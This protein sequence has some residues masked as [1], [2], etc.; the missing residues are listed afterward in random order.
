[1]FVGS[2]RSPFATDIAGAILLGRWERS[3]V[4]IDRLLV[5]V[6]VGFVEEEVLHQFQIKQDKRL[7]KSQPMDV[8][9]QCWW[10]ISMADSELFE[11][12]AG[13]SENLRRFP[14]RN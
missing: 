9:H 12:G 11:S 3:K 10:C 5:R 13:N 14:S 4:G 1:M 8:L 7:R 2:S 6:G